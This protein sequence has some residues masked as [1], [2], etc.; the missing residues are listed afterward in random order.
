MFAIRLISNKQRFRNA[1]NYEYAVEFEKKSV[2]L[3]KVVKTLI[4]KA[5]TI[6]LMELTQ[7]VLLM[8][9][10]LL[11]SVNQLCNLCVINL[12]KLTA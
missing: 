1:R 11:I 9:S 10:N 3:G 4:I 5:E 7:I 6:F 12:N 2:E 8:A